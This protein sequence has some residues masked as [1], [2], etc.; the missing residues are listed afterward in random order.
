MN[1][2]PRTNLSFPFL[3]KVENWLTE[4]FLHFPRRWRC[5]EGAATRCETSPDCRAQKRGSRL[6]NIYNNLTWCSPLAPCRPCPTA[7]KYQVSHATY[8]RE[9]VHYIIPIIRNA[10][11]SWNDENKWNICLVSKKDVK[12]VTKVKLHTSLDEKTCFRMCFSVHFLNQE[13]F[14]FKFLTP[15]MRSNVIQYMH[16]GWE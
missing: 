16:L 6:Q 7:E 15:K 5:R 10:S 9:Q 13:L 2:F 11:L 14:L 8:H 3:T 1:S 4:I 12:V